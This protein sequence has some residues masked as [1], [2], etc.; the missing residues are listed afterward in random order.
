MPVPKNL[1][2]KFQS[3][4]ESIQISL[5]SSLIGAGFLFFLWYVWLNGFFSGESVLFLAGLVIGFSMMKLG[6][7]M[8]RTWK[9]T[10]KK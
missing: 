9:E 4:Y 3:I 1:P 7:L 8:I 2:E 5:Y 6:N 10:H